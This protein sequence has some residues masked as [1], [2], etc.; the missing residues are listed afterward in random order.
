MS[1]L[2]MPLQQRAHK[3]CYYSGRLDPTQLSRRDP[4]YHNLKEWVWT[5][6]KEQ[7]PENWKFSLAPY[8]RENR[9][10]LVSSRSRR[11]CL[12]FLCYF[13]VLSD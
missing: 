12:F 10:P 8:S 3:M 2:M 1:R 11:F 5:I 4:R 13:L 7:L 6:T 9:A